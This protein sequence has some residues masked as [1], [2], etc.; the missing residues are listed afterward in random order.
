MILNKVAPRHEQWWVS[1]MDFGVHK[2]NARIKSYRYQYYNTLKSII[3]NK[4]KKIKCSFY[5]SRTF[6]FWQWWKFIF[7]TPIFIPRPHFHFHL[8]NFQ[9]ISFLV[10]PDLLLS[11][12]NNGLI[13]CFSQYSTCPISTLQLYQNF[14]SIKI[15]LY[16]PRFVWNK[17]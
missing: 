17:T 12:L 9:L 8:S 6:K 13:Y 4:P 3:F 2:I 10:L 1:S 11:F 5:F 14:K 15:I 16:F 7:L